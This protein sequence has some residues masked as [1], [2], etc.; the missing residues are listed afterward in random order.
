MKPVI[1]LS[2]EDAEELSNYLKKKNK[3]SKIKKI[4]SDL[5]KKI[6]LAKGDL[7]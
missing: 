2:V 5:E 7:N 3:D 6:K 4:S 1:I